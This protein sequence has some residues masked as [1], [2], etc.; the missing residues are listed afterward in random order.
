MEFADLFIQPSYGKKIDTDWDVRQ[1]WGG[2]KEVEIRP[3]DLKDYDYVTLSIR[4]KNEVF[5][6]EMKYQFKANY[7]ETICEFTKTKG[8]WGRVK[9]VPKSHYLVSEK[10]LKKIANLLRIWTD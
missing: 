9:W 1:I 3:S 7:M 4:T 10:S 6:P 2:F 8:F 5:H